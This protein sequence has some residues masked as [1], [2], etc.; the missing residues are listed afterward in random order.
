VRTW[1]R[2]WLFFLASILILFGCGKTPRGTEVTVRLV[3]QWGTP[4]TATVIYQVGDGDWEMAAQKEYGVYTFTVPTRETRYGVSVN[5]IPIGLNTF[6]FFYTYQLTTNDATEVVF[7]CL[8]LSDQRFGTI[9]I[10][11]NAKALSGNHLE[12]YGRADDG[13]TSSSPLELEA[14]MS[15]DEPFLFLTFDGIGT[16]DNLKGVR[17]ERFQTTPYM[18][19]NVTFTADDAAKFGRFQGPTPPSDF[20]KSCDFTSGV[21]IHDG[22]FVT[23]VNGLARHE[24]DP[25][26]GNYLRV[27]GTASNDARVLMAGYADSSNDRSLLSLLYAGA[28]SASATLPPLPSPWPASYSVT[29]N[30]LPTFDLNHPDDNVTG[31][32]IFYRGYDGPWWQIFVSPDWLA[33]ASTYTLPDLS[34]APDF[35]GI[36]LFSGEKAEWAVVAF[37]SERS[38]GDWLSTRIWISDNRLANIPVLPGAGMGIASSYGDFEVP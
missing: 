29:A 18:N 27:P 13:Y 6:G 38:I 16:Y 17:F 23:G 20:E 22:I 32:N 14:I 34:G 30:A 1:I 3:N 11:W 33:G 2:W 21:I 28:D 5:C 37:F 15:N 26:S 12:V 24:D 4:A 31:Y 8:N 25:C 35:G 36:K 7:P 9:N 19:H 10:S